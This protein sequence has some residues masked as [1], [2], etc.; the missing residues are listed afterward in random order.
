[1]PAPDP[2]TEPL[3]EGE[4]LPV[5]PEKI[6][7][8]ARVMLQ[9]AESKHQVITGMHLGE[10]K[11]ASY[12]LTGA[13]IITAMAALIDE[14]VH[15]KEANHVDTV[16]QVIIVPLVHAPP[17]GNDT[18]HPLIVEMPEAVEAPP[19]PIS[20]SLTIAIHGVEQSDEQAIANI[21]VTPFCGT[22][23]LEVMGYGPIVKVRVLLGSFMKT[24]RGYWPV[25][26]RY[27][28]PGVTRWHLCT[29]GD[30]HGHERY[31]LFQYL[32]VRDRQRTQK[33]FHPGATRDGNDTEQSER[34]VTTKDT[35]VGEQGFPI[36]GTHIGRQGRPI[37]FR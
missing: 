20:P 28:Y 12:Y 16:P 2:T 6:A 13:Q 10:N 5:F 24:F 9:Y 25:H 33:R 1:M 17:A 19:P 34:L 7:L 27:Q 35:K 31:A 4:Q 18:S 11:T 36:P 15:Q 29:L 23:R 22:I 8:Q 14:A 37:P 32:F 30:R 26:L 21:G 3:Q